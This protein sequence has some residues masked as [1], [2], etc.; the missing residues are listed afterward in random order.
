M[1]R[2]PKIFLILIC[3]MTSV[4]SI[5]AA[6]ARGA[7]P[8]KVV[9]K[10]PL[11]GEGRWDYLIVDNQNRRLFLSRT[12]HVAVLNADSGKSIGE[13]PDTPGVHGIALAPE[14]GV[15]FVS[16]GGENK[17]TVFDLKT[18]KVEKKIDTG[19]N[20]D[21]IVY[22]PDDKLVFVQNGKSNSSSVIDASSRD[23]V[24][25]IPMP[26]RPEFAIYDG[27]GSMYINIEDKSSLAHVDV[28]SKQVKDTWKLT[29]CEG[30]TGLAIDRKSR[31]L[32]SGCAN[33]V[34]AVVNADSGKV[35][36]TVPIGDD[37]DAVA[38][39]PQT[40]YVFASAGEGKLTVIRKGN[41]GKYSVL[42]NLSSPPGSKTM[43]L[44]AAKHEIYLPSAKFNGDPTGHPRPPVVPGSAAMLV[45]AAK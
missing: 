44:D 42:Q 28:A 26:G 6:D 15:G 39:D 7:G 8:F 31:T 2:I 41:G 9:N 40:G 20:P 10:F 22:D 12:T 30:P 21:S 18:L 19:G 27:K 23:V 34:L 25:T 14:L 38:Y 5:S 43:A 17:V 32:F 29:G 1:R 11:P 13:I 16:D 35:L 45:I 37:C 4:L 36:Q 33:K 3:S 24:A